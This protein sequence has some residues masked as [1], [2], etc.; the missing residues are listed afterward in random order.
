MSLF[1]NVNIITVKMSIKIHSEHDGV[2]VRE[3][4][5]AYTDPTYTIRY[6]LQATLTWSRLVRKP[7][8]QW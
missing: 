2:Y 4:K 6:L 5:Q 7:N 3:H 8:G 1:N